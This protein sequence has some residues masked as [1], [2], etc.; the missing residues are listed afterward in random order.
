MIAHGDELGRTQQGNNNTYAQDSEL[1]W[2]HWEEADDDLIEFT[3]GLTRLRAKHPTFRRV[4]FFNGRPVT[5][6]AG[7]PLPDIEWLNT[8]AAPMTDEDWDT[9]FV[10][11]AGVFLNGQGIRGRDP[12]GQRILDD[13]A[14]LYFNA[15]ENDV[16]FQLPAE[17]YGARWEIV[18]DTAAGASDEHVPA[19]SPLHVRSRS[20]VVL[21]ARA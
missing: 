4:R 9:D 8:E 12:R 5:R 16:D 7:E 10:K 18:V 15:S 17:E 1:S 2:I 21:M 3:A 13:N 20:M 11:A 14:L 6:G 19:G